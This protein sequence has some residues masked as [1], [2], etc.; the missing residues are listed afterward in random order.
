MQFAIFAKTLQRIFGKQRVTFVGQMRHFRRR[1]N[2][3]EIRM[4]AVNDS[5]EQGH[6]YAVH[7]VIGC[8]GPGVRPELLQNGLCG[9]AA[10]AKFID[11]AG[12]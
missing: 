2:G 4:R 6:R 5:F 10:S 9:A 12:K 8:A 11:R 3:G 1:A 7:F